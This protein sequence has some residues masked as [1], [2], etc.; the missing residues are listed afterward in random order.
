MHKHTTCGH[1]TCRFR[2]VFERNVPPQTLATVDIDAAA[3][4]DTFHTVNRY[5]QS[6]NNSCHQNPWI[7]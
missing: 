5:T 6:F 2:W 3:E 7:T 4:S 1:K